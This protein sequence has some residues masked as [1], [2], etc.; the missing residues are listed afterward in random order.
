MEPQIV[1][2]EAFTLVGVV[3]HFSSAAENFGPLWEVEFMAHHDWLEPQ[4]ADKA[5]YGVYLGDHDK[6]LDYVAGMS[7]E[8]GASVPEGLVAHEMPAGLYAA[9]ECTLQTLGPTWGH[10]W[11]EWLPGSEYEL[12]PSR[13]TFDLY[14]PGTGS[15]EMV[16][17]V[18]V[19]IVAATG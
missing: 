17:H 3:G 15:G 2:R 19:P 1:N 9:F 16:V 14:P 11:D 6:P 18:Y 10:I 13:F 5:Y 8:S 12:D 4:S 7:V